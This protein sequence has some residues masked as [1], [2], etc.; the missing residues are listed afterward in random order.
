MAGGRL[1]ADRLWSRWGT[2]GLLRR[3]GTLAAIGFTL[4]LARGTTLSGI[5]GFAAFGLGLAG[6]IPTLFRS[7][8]AEPGIPTGSAL[9]AVA[10]LGYLGFL[11]GPPLIGGLA[12]LT[13]LRVASTLLALA[14]V[15]VV[16]LAPSA[17]EPSIRSSSAER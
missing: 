16:V 9:A 10:S 8:A 14:A 1:I 2:T 13:T 7:A 6:V 17:R 15:V 5:A 3:S 12:Q 11:A 4:G